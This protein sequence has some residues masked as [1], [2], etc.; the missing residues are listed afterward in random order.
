MGEPKLTIAISTGCNE[1]LRKR[2]MES[3]E[4][5]KTSFSVQVLSA[6]PTASAPGPFKDNLARVRNRMY[7]EA[8]GR[9]V[10]F[11]DEDTELPSPYFLERLVERLER[12]GGAVG[13]GYAGGGGLWQAAYNALTSYWLDLHARQGQSLPVAGNFAMPRM[14]GTGIGFPF[15][16]QVPFGGEEIELRRAL[17]RVGMKFTLAPELAVLHNSSKTGRR[18]F[19]RAWTHGSSPR[20]PARNGMAFRTLLR[21]FAGI[22]SFRI[23]TLM[24]AYL[25]TVVTARIAWHILPRKMA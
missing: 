5:Q 6:A 4:S 13:G 23:R 2:L 1:A 8:R 3:I 21:S 11:L 25:A 20:M 15:S 14:P 22:D 24:V 10:Y 9:W 16:L 19:E 12:E 17:L 18:F 7:A